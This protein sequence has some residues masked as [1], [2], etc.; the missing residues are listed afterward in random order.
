MVPLELMITTGGVAAL[1]NAQNGSTERIK[2]VSVGLTQNAFIMAPTLT[3][4]PGEIK[5]VESVSGEATSAS[6]I[7]MTM[8]DISTDS[9]DLRGIGLYLEDGTLFAVYSQAEPIF[10]K[11]SVAFFL[12]AL[13][14]AFANN[15]AGD[16]EFGDTTFLMPPASETVKGVAEVATPAEAAAGTDHGRIITPLT[17][18]QRLAALGAAVDADLDALADG[19]DTL[20]AALVART[21]TGSGLVTG[22]GDL[23]ASRILSVLAASAGD[24]ASGAA[25]DRAVTPA[26]L[27]GLARSLA[28]N[29]YATLPGCGGL[30]IQWGRFSAAANGTTNV[31]FPIAFPVECF[32]VAVAGGSPSGVDSQDNPPVLVTSGIER[33]GFPVFS[34]DDTAD[35][36]AYIAV[37]A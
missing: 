23:S 29:G 27:S 2:I 34:A 13:D 28:Q 36:C 33:S 14:V 30:I 37:G 4:L 8:Q 3:A 11:V 9:Y 35:G 16:I 10:T 25:G 1:V 24:V 19:F 5:R 15:A 21:I 18:A 26:A 31:L 6:V 12:L 22:G 20:L 17:L 32:S 7:H